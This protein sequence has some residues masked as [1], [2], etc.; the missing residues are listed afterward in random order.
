MF[1]V[2]LHSH[3]EGSHDGR[4]P[5][6][7]MLGRAESIGL[8]AIAVTDHDAIEESLRAVETATEYDV[9]AIP[10]IEVSS[11]A[12]HVLAL[13][14]EELVPARLPFEETVD[15]IHELGGTAVVPHPY[16]DLREGVLANVGEERIAIADAIEVFNS[17]FL[18]G[19]TNRRA[20][21]LATERGMPMTAG[22]DAH[23]SGMIGRGTTLVDA[24]ECTVEGILDAIRAGNTEI[25]GRR[26]PLRVTLRQAGGTAK[27]R[28]RKRV[29]TYL[30]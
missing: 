10:G 13:G 9:V 12:G 24:E 21:K 11:E 26:T 15:R 4:D 27:R 1:A 23:V 17:R 6:E 22:S 16:Q 8:D 29:G 18:T 2:E 20:R 5:V 14:V 28:L 25:D 19:R 30:K 7:R 3:S